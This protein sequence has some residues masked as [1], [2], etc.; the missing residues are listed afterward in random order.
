MTSAEIHAEA[1]TNDRG[2]EQ[3][4]GEAAGIEVVSV[5]DGEIRRRGRAASAR[6]GERIPAGGQDNADEEQVLRHGLRMTGMSVAGKTEFRMGDKKNLWTGR[7]GAR[8]LRV[9]AARAAAPC[10]A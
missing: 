6:G 1:E 10:G 2:L 7:P 3:E 4:F 9:L 5:G 8:A